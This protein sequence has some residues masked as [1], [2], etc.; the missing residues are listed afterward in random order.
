MFKFMSGTLSKLSCNILGL[1]FGELQGLEVVGPRPAAGEDPLERG[2]HGP[3]DAGGEQGGSAVVLHDDQAV[4]GP[5]HRNAGVDS[6]A[7]GPPAQSHADGP[8]GLEE[9]Q[10]ALSVGKKRLS[11]QTVEVSV[12][13]AAPARLASKAAHVPLHFARQREVRQHAWKYMHWAKGARLKTPRATS[14]PTSTAVLAARHCWQTYMAQGLVSHIFKESPAH[15]GDCRPGMLS[16][17]SLS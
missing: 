12:D 9:R 14:T 15:A 16:T 11:T 7:A 3:V 1:E 8:G 4:L 17:T 10:S 2:G 13:G 5:G 6:A